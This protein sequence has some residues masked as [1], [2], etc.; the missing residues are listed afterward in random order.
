MT[1]THHLS[2]TPEGVLVA[3]PNLD[4]ASVLALATPDGRAVLTP[5]P[6]QAAIVEFPPEPLLVVA[7]AGAGKTATMSMRVLWLVANRGFDPR[8]ILGLTFSRKS[9]GE[10]GAKMR[11][12]LQ[13]LA[14]HLGGTLDGEPTALTY[15]SFAQRIVLEHGMHIGLDPDLSLIGRARA[16]K[17]MT[18]VI[19]RWPTALPREVALS[20][21]VKDALA[22][23]GH[24][25]EHDMSLDQA[26]EALIALGQD[27]AEIGSPTADLRDAL[28][29]NEARLLL[30]D[31][32]EEFDRR[33]RAMGV[34]D[35]SDQLVLAT[36]IVTSTPEVVSQLREEHR[37]VLLDEFQD[38]SVI[39]MNLLSTLFHDHPV[40]AVGDPNQAIYGWRGASASSLESFLQR[41]TT[42]GD[43]RPDQTRTLST[44]WRN[45]RRILVAANAVAQPLRAHSVRAKS[46]LLRP[47]PGAGTGHVEVAHVA[48]R[49]AQMNTVVDFVQRTRHQEGGRRSTCAILCRRRRDF[50]DVERALRE[51]GIPTHI[52]DLGGLLAQPAVADVR[53][54]L[55]LAQ[56][57]SAAQ[58]LPRLLVAMDLGTAD[59]ALLGKWARQQARSSAEAAGVGAK[60]AAHPTTILLSAVDDPPEAGWRPRG[61]DGP[62]FSR[63]A[64]ERVSLLAR[65]LRAVR[66]GL[67]RGVV[68]QVERTIGILGLVEDLI[69]DPLSNSGRESLDALVDV[70]LTYEAEVPG[71]D[72]RGFLQWLAVAEAEEDGLARPVDSP[73]PGAVDILT[74]H[75][76]KGLEWDS[77]AVVSMGD[78]IFPSHSSKPVDWRSDPA[79]SSGWLKARSEL[80]YPIR[81]DAA[82][83]PELV[84]GLGEVISLSEHFH[85]LMAEATSSRST[86]TSLFNRHVREVAR[87]AFGAH[88]EREERRLAYVALTRAR[89]D[90]LLVGSWVDFST[91]PKFPSRY[92]MEARAALHALFTGQTDL[93]G[94]SDPACRGDCTGPEESADR[95]CAAEERHSDDPASSAAVG[96][97]D[98]ASRAREIDALD[99]AVQAVPTDEQ[100]AE[101][102]VDD[103]PVIHPLPEGPSRRRVRL[104]AERLETL[105]ASMRTDRDVLAELEDL[106]AEPLVRDTIALVEERRLHAEGHAARQVEVDR[107]AA[108]SVND[109]M[110]APEDFAAHLR[111]PLP[112]QPRA[113]SML[114][115][116][117]HQWIEGELRVSTGTLW[118]VEVPGVEALGPRER[119][120]LA[121][122]QDNF[123]HLDLLRT[124]EVVAVEEPFAVDVGGVSVQGRIDA[125]LRGRDGRDVVVDWK[126]GR[127]VGPGS[128]PKDIAYYATQL[129]LYR[130]A[131]ARRCGKAEDEVGTA[132]VFLEEP[133]TFT[134]EELLSMLARRGVA[135]PT[136][137]DRA[138]GAGLD[139][140]HLRL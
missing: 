54:A 91:T 72:M 88:A 18:E 51:A 41:F 92:L 100:I 2:L 56:D 15:N 84:E 130:R 122:M 32:V 79:P 16:V 29:A 136:D 134:V 7:G 31:L 61:S 43:V 70:A 30:L 35:Y 113:S 119:R 110:S 112:V 22:M 20:T 83:L 102:A 49:A 89:H 115:S 125:V 6:E 116:L 68:D 101:M 127:V 85:G 93:V 99:A 36:R 27:L 65:R 17:L 103:D 63:A 11:Q 45:D 64:H 60:G 10:L 81:G 67:G 4:A 117:L 14:G 97:L 129:R 53:A 48:D 13:V 123:R 128:D 55:E 94:G 38:T 124:H 71:A 95:M 59:M 57:P 111:R 105:R 137:L 23:A 58:W 120:R 37:A 28:A 66:A 96:D 69:A 78:S 39:Q 40:T 74:V 62:R 98:A 109:L 3:D 50:P 73:A 19:D 9:A 77:V 42:V 108:T 139:A 135:A 26:R 138:V 33:K 140:A 107:L 44:A 106:D 12:D 118:D 86:P 131:R 132:V 8:S 24:V 90:M 52:C 82:D 34:I 114:G 121:T 46:P 104:S 76:A 47:R 75:S 1:L 133:A 87:A 21:W 80:P 5:T 126:S 25:G